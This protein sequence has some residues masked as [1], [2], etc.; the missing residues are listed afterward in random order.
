MSG[1]LEALFVFYVLGSIMSFF[2][3]L[4]WVC[5]AMEDRARA[6]NPRARTEAARQAL[7][8]C[9]AVLWLP[10]V[11]PIWVVWCVGLGLWDLVDE[12]WGSDE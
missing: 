6:R 9:S 10:V 8:W 2:G 5:S 1:F 11:W 3:A 7:F 4:V 12:A